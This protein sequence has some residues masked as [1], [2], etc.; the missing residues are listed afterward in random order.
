MYSGACDGGFVK[1]CASCS[2]DL[3]EAALHCVFCGAKQ[4]PAPA[5]Q[6][7][8]AKTAFGYS[9]NEVM[10]QL[11]RPGA[12]PQAAPQYQP[13]ASTSPYS[14]RNQPASQPP[15]YGQPQQPY[16]Q[17]P[18]Q[19]G[20]PQQGGLAPQSNPHAATIAIAPGGGPAPLQYAQTQP[21]PYQQQQQPYQPNAGAY[22]VPY[23]QPSGMGINAPNPHTPPPLG[24]MSGQPPYLGAQ[25]AGPVPIEPW[26]YALRLH[27]IVWGAVML[28][29][30]AVPVTT[31]PMA[32]HWDGI[33]DMPAKMLIMTLLFP[34]VGALAVAFGSGPLPA[35]VRGSI[36]VA[37]GLAT[38]V[39]PLALAGDAPPWQFFVG[40]VA[41][42]TLIPGLLVRNEYTESMVARVL[43][44]IGVICMILPL[45]VPE[46][47]ELKLVQ[48]FKALIDAPGK[49]KVMPIVEIVEVVL[50]VLSLL[51]W[52]PGPAT[53]GAK[54]F[55]WAIILWSTLG[56]TL[57]QILIS[58]DIGA[59]F[60]KAP[61]HVVE[62]GLEAAV[63]VLIGYGGATVVGKQ[64]E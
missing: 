5:V 1:K 42:L 45:L 54:I 61:G 47:G 35:M 43:V 23:Q 37:L 24:P 63:M 18:Q 48:L 10:N 3:P 13:P 28:V 34:I 2:K 52:M 6:P 56:R 62:W 64:L 4:A 14:Q 19:G 49:G 59:A 7:G 58:H 12:P 32:F 46:G 44:T 15:P 17:G 27:M 38:I 57:A 16:N 31:D 51:A 9:A 33:G 8:L 25:H 30:F 21:A 50:V 26:R 39:T 29:V 60:T 55:A 40:L 36:A 11:G 22:Q 41:I 53:G 20:Y